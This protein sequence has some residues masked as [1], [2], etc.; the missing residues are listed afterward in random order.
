MELKSVRSQRQTDD[1]ADMALSNAPAK[2]DSM[3]GSRNAWNGL[4]VIG[5]KHENAGLW[6]VENCIFPITPRK[7]STAAP[8][9]PNKG[10]LCRDLL[11]RKFSWDSYVRRR[12][13]EH[14]SRGSRV[15]QHGSHYV[16]FGLR[17]FGSSERTL[18]TSFDE[19]F[20][21]LVFVY[22]WNSCK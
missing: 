8:K 19:E 9:I 7:M 18:V 22:V 13:Y 20:V 6:L 12:R 16:N 11:C 5:C 17:C 15:T 14:F 21:L 3:N 1:S 2:P 10:V 4:A